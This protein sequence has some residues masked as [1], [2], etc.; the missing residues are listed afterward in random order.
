MKTNKETILITGGLGF[1]GS[2]LAKKLHDKYNI[3][4][5]DFD[6]SKNA[7][8]IAR[9]F[10]LR[11]AEIIHGDIASTDTWRKIPK[12]QYIF[13]AAAQVSAEVSWEKPELDFRANVHG[14]FHV[15]EHARKHRAHIFYCNT[16]RV[17]DPDAIA[18]AME[19]HGKV[20]EKC[21]TIDV[22]KKPQPPFALSKYFGEQYLR[23]Y[24]NMH[25]L[26]VISHRMSGI[27]GPG[28]IGSKNHGW[29]ANIVRCAVKKKE[30]TI[31]GDGNQTRDILHINDFLALVEDEIYDF[32]KYSEGGFAF[33]NV[34]GGPANE[35]SINRVVQI[36]DK[37]FSIRI[38]PQKIGAL[39]GEPRRYASDITKITEKGWSGHKTDKKH[40]L[41]DLVNWYAT[42]KRRD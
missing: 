37:D 19:K 24:A 33:Y 8:K 27:V 26:E 7:E 17:Y 15:A 25:G 35:L 34:G 20:S 32:N 13:H 36:L 42:G 28:Q 23:Y 21:D 5:V 4:I 29:I 12:C 30:Y 22:S 3:V 10:Q 9:D 31:F 6:H 18:L 11:G 14:T 1:I 40:I 41:K 39:V 16:I 2:N 38:K